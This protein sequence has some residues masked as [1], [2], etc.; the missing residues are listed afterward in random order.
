MLQAGSSWSGNFTLPAKACTPMVTIRTSAL[1]AFPQGVRA[2]PSQVGSMASIISPNS[3]PA[4]NA[5]PGACGYQLVGI[6]ATVQSGTINYSIIVL[7]SGSETSAGLPSTIFIE[8]SWIHGT[9]TCDCKRGVQMNGKNQ[10]V[11]DS[12]IT[13]I[14]YQGIDSQAIE[15]WAG[16]GPFKVV[17]N[18]LQAGSEVVSFGGALP[19]IVGT[20]PSDIEIRRN[21]ISRPLA[22]IGAGW[23]VKNLFELKNAQRVVFDSNVAENN[24][25]EAQVG[26]AILF[27]GFTKD[28]GDWAVVSDVTVTNNIIRH[29]AN[30]IVLCGGCLA[31]PTAPPGS[32]TS[33][34]YIANNLLDDIGN[35]AYTRGEFGN[36]YALEVL[37]DTSSVVVDHNTFVNVTASGAVLLDGPPS[38]GISLT[39]NIFGHGTYGIIGNS[40]GSGTLAINQYLPGSVVTGN[41]LAAAPAGGLSSYPPGNAFP[42][43]WAAVQFV[44]FNNGNGGDYHL[45]SQSPFFTGGVGASTPG[46]DITTLNANTAN[47]ISGSAFAITITSPTSSSTFTTS[48][49]SLNLS[50]TAF[51]SA[52]ITQVTWQTDHG[53]SGIATGASNWTIAGLTLP[54]GIT[55]VTVTARNATGNQ[56]STALA[57]TYT[58]DSTAPVIAITSPTSSGSYSAS[59]S[60]VNLAGTASDDV[61]VT[62]VTW[63]TDKGATGTATGTSNWTITGVPVLAGS[64]QITVTAHDAAGNASSALLAVTSSFSGLSDTTPPT[65]VITSPTS[66]SSF[67]ASS[68]TISIAGTAS[69]NAAVTQVTWSTDKGASGIAAGT[70]SWTINGLTLASGTTQITVTASDTSGN[71]ASRSLTVAYTS[72]D[73]TSPTI[74][75][76]AP[77]TGTTFSTSGTSVTISGIAADNVAVTQ[78]GWVTDRG[79]SGVAIGT[80]SWSTGAIPLQGGSTQITVI[81]YDKAGNQAQRVLAVTTPPQADTTPPTISITSPTS[82]ATFSTTGTTISLSGTATDNVGV[83]QVTWVSSAGGSGLAAGTSSWNASGIALQSGSNQL[84]VTARDAAGNQRSAVITVTS[85]ALN[86]V[87][88]SSVVITS[89]TS[90]PVYTTSVDTVS[91]AGTASASAGVIQV[92]WS[93]DRGDGSGVATGTTSWVVNQVNLKNGTNTITIT[94]RDSANDLSS[95]VIQVVYSPPSVKT[96]NLPK[97]QAG[98]QY[99]YSLAVDGGV[100]PYSWSA[101]ALP[102]GMSLSTDGLLTGKPL[103][104]GTYDVGIVVH[105]SAVSDSVTLTLSVDPWV[106]FVSTAT[107]SPA[108][109]APQSML[110]AVGWQLSAGT[111]TA[112]PGSLPT[113]LADTT[114][115]VR[116]AEGKDHLS[117]LYYVSPDQIN[118]VVPAETALGN[119]TITIASAGRSVI[120]DTIYVA[121]VAPSIFEA[122]AE[123]LAAANLLRVRGNASEYDPI[124]Q[125]D[126]TTSQVVAIPIDLSPDTDSFYLILYGTGVRFRSSVD[127]VKAT[128]GGIDSQVVYAGSAGSSDG[129]DV[130]SIKLPTEVHG[131]ADVVTTVDG[132][133]ANTVRILI[134]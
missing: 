127:S 107:F 44:N 21:H 18:D 17:N 14:H 62:Q 2:T 132:V 39:S 26:Y 98:Q 68:S 24:W 4:I 130:L 61:A 55:R 121:S 46:A 104:T 72:P 89:P 79:G 123:G 99:T 92:T 53:A 91:L 80:T 94:A 70:T 112:D 97:A 58:P 85:T 20:I 65:I 51:D 134:K 48:S 35:P 126:P 63:A 25:V 128:V 32:K 74:A 57:L 118:F 114:V 77:T 117:P 100:P 82:A 88:S 19:T 115:T 103:T 64:T 16:P 124:S 93:A 106:D 73:T 54:D 110:T 52:G 129:L 102:A 76:T 36:G 86:P 81:A 6:E 45:S 69:D 84:T 9:P 8:R 15:G 1:A 125:R 111:A 75:I 33:R 59:S 3:A 122:N 31:S 116:D 120:S 66:G 47:S 49:S 29:S 43:S 101:S 27:Q 56:V 11:V 34:I 67:T 50:G 131:W 133:A 40:F 22:W 96:K 30:G 12:T 37:S 78:V 113:I 71:V 5:A 7:G 109:A 23:L 119:A 105:D 38:P 108:W 83:T 28:S 13:D 87:K 90:S 42:P 10:A 41:L 95:Q 60:S